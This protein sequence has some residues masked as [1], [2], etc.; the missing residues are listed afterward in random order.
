V[1]ALPIV[2]ITQGATATVCN[3]GSIILDGTGAS[4]YSWSGVDASGNTI[5]DGTSFIPPGSTT[6]TYTVTGTDGNGCTNTALIQVTATTGPTITMS[7]SPSTICAGETVTLTANGLD[8]VLPG[9]NYAWSAGLGLGQTI[10]VTPTTTTT[11]SVTGTDANGCIGTDQQTVMVNP[12]PAAPTINPSSVTEYC[13]GDLNPSAITVTANAGH[14]VNWYNSSMQFLYSGANGPVPNTSNPGTLTYYATQSNQ[15]TG[16][17]SLSLMVEVDIFDLPVIVSNDRTICLG[18]TIILSASGA[19]SGGTYSWSTVG[20]SLSSVNITPTTSGVYTVTGTD[21]NGCAGTKTINVTVNQTPTSP[22]VISPVEYCKDETAVALTASATGGSTL[23]W[24]ELDGVTKRANPSVAPFPQTTSIGSTYYHVSQSN[25]TGCEGPQDSIEVIVHPLPITPTVTTTAYSYCINEPATALAATAKDANHTL[26]WY[27]INGLPTNSSTPPTPSTT[28]QGTVTYS[29]S[30]IN[31][32]TGCESPRVDITVT[33]VNGPGLPTIISPVEYCKDESAIAL[34][35]TTTDAS[36]TLKWYDM[37]GDPI[38][39]PPTPL[40]NFAGTQTY[41]V[42]QVTSSGCEGSLASLSVNVHNNPV[43]E[44]GPNR[45]V[46]EGDQIILAGSGVSNPPTSPAQTYTWSGGV[47]DNIPFAITTT[48]MYTVTGTDI[49]GCFASDDITVTVSSTPPAPT[50]TNTVVE[51]CEGEVSGPLDLEVGLTAPVSGYDFKWYDTDGILLPNAPTHPTGTPGTLTYAVSLVSNDSLGCEGP[52]TLITVIVNELPDAPVTVDI[53]NCFGGTSTA[54]TA[55]AD[56]GN[57]LQWYSTDG[58]TPI[59]TPG[60]PTL[61]VGSVTY[62]VSQIDPTGC[63]SPKASL[64]ITTH[65]VPNIS[66]GSDVTVC[67]GDQVILEGSGG[68]VG[69]SYTWSGGIS[70]GVAF[71]PTN[72]LGET[73]YVTGTDGFGCQ[74]TDTVLVT[75][76]PLPAAPTLIDAS[77]FEY[78]LGDAASPLNTA[79]QVA[80]SGGQRKWYLPGPGGSVSLSGPPTPSTSVVGTFV[81]EVSFVSTNLGCESPKTQITI[82][83][84]DVPSA[85]LTTT[86]EYCLGEPNPLPLTATELAGYTLKWYD[87]DGQ[88]HLN[89]GAPTP[90]T[91]TV[92]TVT[93]YVSQVSPY[94]TI[95]NAQML[96][97]EGVKGTLDVVTHDL[98]TITAVAITPSNTTTICEGDEI[99]LSGQGAGFS[100]TYNWTNGVNDGTAFIPTSTTTY[101]V[102]GVD[103]NTC[104]NIASVTITVNPEPLPFEVTPDVYDTKSGVNY[105]SSICDLDS[106]QLSTNISS[107]TGTVTWYKINTAVTPNDT[108]FFTTGFNVPKTNQAGK[109]FAVY[110][111][112]L[113]CSKISDNYIQL[114]VE[115]LIQPSFFQ[116]PTFYNSSNNTYTNCA[117]SAEIVMNAPFVANASYTILRYNSIASQ[118]DSVASVTS[119]DPSYSPTQSGRYRI[120]AE[121]NGCSHKFSQEIVVVLTDLPKP[122]LSQVFGSGALCNINDLNINIDNEQAYTAFPGAVFTV[123]S[124][125]PDS[126][127]IGNVNQFTKLANGNYAPWS[128][129]VINGHYEDSTHT[130]RFIEYYVQASAGGCVSPIDTLLVEQYYSP[131]ER[132]IILA[133]GVTSTTYNVCSS[134][135]VVDLQPDELTPFVRYEWYDADLYDSNY[136][137]ISPLAQ[138]FD[139]TIYNLNLLNIGSKRLYLVGYTISG[140]MSSNFGEIFVSKSVPTPPTIRYSHTADDTEYICSSIPGIVS[141]DI[142]IETPINGNR[143]ELYRVNNT[144]PG[145]AVSTIEY[146]QEG[147]TFDAMNQIGTYRAFSIDTN[148]CESDFGNSLFMEAV[149]VIKPQIAYPS[150]TNLPL[151]VC[152]NDDVNLQLNNWIAYSNLSTVTD[153]VFSWYRVESAGDVF[154]G[155]SNSSVKQV[156]VGENTTGILSFDAKF[157]V[158]A[159]HVLMGACAMTSDT[160]NIDVRNTPSAPVVSAYP[161]DT[162]CLGEDIDLV[163]LSSDALIPNPNYKWYYVNPDGTLNSQVGIGDT[164]TR[165]PSVGGTYTFAAVAENSGCPGPATTIDFFVRDLTP[166]ILEPV[167]AW[168][169]GVFNVCKDST[170]DLRVSTPMLDGATYELYRKDLISGNFNPYPTQSNVLQ[171]IYDSS[172]PNSNVFPDVEEGEYRVKVIQGN[173]EEFGTVSMSIDEILLNKP[174]I[175]YAPSEPSSLCT[176]STTIL[177]MDGGE[178]VGA[179]YLWNAIDITSGGTSLVTNGSDHS[180]NVPNTNDLSVTPGFSGLGTKLTDYYLTSAMSAS[181]GKVCRT[182]SDTLRITAYDRPAGPEYAGTA[183]IPPI[184]EVCIGSNDIL[185]ADAPTSAVYDWSWYKTN[186]SLAPSQTDVING[187]NSDSLTVSSGG[188]YYASVT[189]A[190]GCMSNR[191]FI[192]EYDFVAPVQAQFEAVA[193]PDNGI[194]QICADSVGTLEVSNPVIGAEYTLYQEDANGAFVRLPATSFTHSLGATPRFTGLGEGIYKVEVDEDL[195]NPI[196]SDAS[197][198]IERITIQDYDIQLVQGYNQEVCQDELT[199]LKLTR[200]LQKI[201][202]GGNFNEIV[203][204]YDENGNFIDDTEILIVPTSS[205]TPS[206]GL[207]YTAEVYGKVNGDYKCPKSP[208]NDF[209]IIV[210]PN[211]P[212]PVL[213][214]QY[215]FCEGESMVLRTMDNTADSNFLSGS[216]GFR[217]YYQQTPL[218]VVDTLISHTSAVLT[219]ND[220][221][222]TASGY[223]STDYISTKGCESETSYYSKVD[224]DSVQTPGFRPLIAPQIWP[225]PLPPNW[226]VGR[227][228]EWLICPNDTSFFVVTNLDP[229]DVG[230]RYHLQMQASNGQWQDIPSR[231]FDYPSATGSTV[232]Q[233]YGF[234][235]SLTG[236]YRVRA[237]KYSGVHAGSCKNKFSAPVYVR[238]DEEPDPIITA[239]NLSLCTSPPSGTPVTSSTT[240]YVTNLPNPTVRPGASY[241]WYRRDVTGLYATDPLVAITTGTLTVSQGG[242]YYA[243]LKYGADS[244]SLNPRTCQV[245]SND[246][247]IVENISP[248]NPNT[249]GAPPYYICEST[250]NGLST[251]QVRIDTVTLRSY[252]NYYWYD[253]NN[254]GVVKSQGSM[255][256][257][258]QGEYQIVAENNGCFSDTFD[259]DI[260][261][262]DID[263]PI[264]TPQDGTIC[265]QDSLLLQIVNPE[266]GIKYKWYRDGT[267]NVLDSGWNY[268]APSIAGAYYTIGY[269]EGSTDATGNTALTCQSQAS[270]FVPI[271]VHLMPSTPVHVDLYMCSDDYITPLSDFLNVPFGLTPYWYISG[272]TEIPL[273]FGDN[274][275]LDQVSFTG[276]DT[277]SLWV[278]YKDD[279]TGCFSARTEMDLYTIQ[280]PTESPIVEDTVVCSGAAFNLG[281]MVKNWTGSN[282]ALRIYDVDGN[283]VSEWNNEIIT[284]DHDSTYIYTFNFGSNLTMN[285]LRCYSGNTQA[286][287]T[288]KAT[289]PTPSVDPIAFSYCEGEDA[290]D[291]LYRLSPYI[292][293]SIT[294][295]LNWYTNPNIN[296][297]SALISAPAI[298]TVLPGAGPV[299]YE[300]WLTRRNWVCE[301]QP[302]QLQIGVN[303][304]PSSSV[305]KD[306]S[307]VLCNQP[308]YQLATNQ[309]YSPLVLSWYSNQP[310]GPGD[311]TGGFV[312]NGLA[313]TE[314]W[315]YA[316]K[317]DAISGCESDFDSVKVRISINQETPRALFGGIDTVICSSQTPFGLN[318]LFD[319]DSLNY[320]LVWYTD[321]SGSN[322]TLIAPYYIP[323]LS[324]DSVAV[325]VGL[326]D[327]EN[328]AGPIT[329]YLIRKSITPSAPITRDTAY[330]LGGDVAPVEDLVNRLPSL[331]YTY[332]DDPFFGQGT[333]AYSLGQPEEDVYVYVSATN[334]Y[335][336]ESDRSIIG[337]DIFKDTG[338][339]ITA[340]P[341]VIPDGGLTTL[342]ATGANTYVF[343]G[344]GSWDDGAIGSDSTSPAQLTLQPDSVGTKWYKVRGTRDS[345]GCIGVDSVQVHVNAFDP[346]TIGFDVEFCAGQR[347]TEVRNVTYP[348]GGSGNYMFEW[349]IGSPVGD[350]ILQVNTPTLTFPLGLL[351][352]SYYQDTLRIMRRAIDSEALAI[353]DTVTISIVNVPPINIVEIDDDYEIPTGHLTNYTAF[354]NHQVDFNVAYKWLIDSVDA[355]VYDDTLTNVYLDSG[356]HV[357]EGRIYYVD[358]LGRMRCHRSSMVTVDVSDLIPGVLNPEQTVCY[359]EKPQDLYVIDSASGGSG[360]Y[361]YSWEFYD[362]IDSVWEPYLDTAG[363]I[364]TDPIL[365]FDPTVGF[366]ESQKFRRVVTDHSVTKFTVATHIT[367]LPKPEPPIVDT[368]IVCFGNWVGALGATPTA[369]YEVEWYNYN[370][371]TSLRSDA[372]VMDSLYAGDQIYYVAQRDTIFG[373]LSDL[374]KVV[375]RMQGLPLPPT[376]IP[377]VVCE[378]DTVQIELSADSTIANYELLWFEKDT[379]T[380]IAGTP[381]ISGA[382]LDSNDRFF[383]AQMDTITGCVSEKVE[384]PI[385]LKYLPEGEIV[386]GVDNFTV[387]LGEYITLSLQPYQGYNQVIWY[388]VTPFDTLI[389]DTAASISVNPTKSTLYLARAITDLNCYVEYYQNVTVQELP[390]SPYLRSYEY[391]QNEDATTIIADSLYAGNAL[392]FYNTLTQIDTVTF[393]P[394]PPT[395]SVGIFKYYA[396]QYDSI[397]G[398]I[399]EIDTSI[400]RVLGRPR[401]PLQRSQYFCLGTPDTLAVDKGYGTDN[402]L[403]KLE[404]FDMDNNGL[405]STPVISTSDT[406][407]FYF[408][409]RNEDLNTGCFSELT[410]IEA[411]VYEHYI[412]SVLYDDSTT[413]FND[414]DAVVTV[415]VEGPFIT[416]WFYVNQNGWESATFADSTSATVPAGQ[417]FV[418]TRDTAGCEVHRDTSIDYFI[419]QEPDM[420]TLDSVHVVTQIQCYDSTDAIIQ[421]WASGGNIIE[422]S[423]DSLNFQSSALFTGLGP[424]EYWPTI[425]DNKGCDWM[426]SSRYDSLELIEPDPIYVNFITEDLLCASDFTGKVTATLQGGNWDS[427]EINYGWNY[428]WVYDST[429]AEY[430]QKGYHLNL[431]NPIMDSLWAGDYFLTAT[432]YKGC[433]LTDTVTLNQPDSVIVDSIYSRNVT[434]FDSSNAIIEIFAN[435]GTSLTYSLD[436]IAT[437]FGTQT[438]WDNLSQ[439]DTLY[440]SVADTNSCFVSYKDNRRVIFDSLELFEATDVIIT[441]PLCFN[442]STGRIEVITKGGSYPL[443]NIDSTSFIYADSLAFNRLPSDTVYITVTDTNSCTPVYAFNRKIFIDQPDKLNVNAITDSNV[444]CFEDTTGIISGTIS[445]GTLPYD[446]LWSNGTIALWDSAVAGGLYYLE[447]IDGNDCYA[448]DSTVV[449]SFDR[450]C[451]GIPDSVETFSDCDWDG[452][453]N[454]YDLDSDNDGIPDALEYDYD[455]NGIVGDDCDGDGIPNYCDP[456]LCEFFIPSVITPNFDGKNDALEIPGLQYFDNYKFTVYNIYGN[457]VF[458][459]VNQGSG[460]GGTTQ[461]RVVWFNNDGELP[462]G[463]YFYVLEIR[464][465]K[466]RQS[467]YIYIAR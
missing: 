63:E 82:I 185:G 397:T 420:L 288:V 350:T 2:G 431:H 461:N 446:V 172:V 440:V 79:L 203:R 102:T 109:Y 412:E 12:V 200:P 293:D 423:V 443:L 62:Y 183:L 370:N 228:P 302:T 273:G 186:N 110:E 304:K 411:I 312:L 409:V 81:Y 450:D 86:V 407:H 65:S 227:G 393:L 396:S 381:I 363:V 69:A 364:V 64:T 338:V 125:A 345:T 320:D 277:T 56:Q 161:T 276:T 77:T 189:D 404:W 105:I 366:T 466:W 463:T 45:W 211:P 94:V 229:Y 373:C 14:I 327:K 349:W 220:V 455:R 255:A 441:E 180:I 235:I 197:I 385:T 439:G 286:M 372:P 335:G 267:S 289:P 275:F 356:R 421:L 346:G 219:I 95:N 419:V 426:N 336:C 389:V 136:P 464:P 322:P 433:F 128:P 210:N 206:S 34:T 384:S 250:T 224:I 448:F 151:T 223:Y 334:I 251:K 307:I 192:M 135:P 89:A 57:T 268:Y 168:S 262:L 355:G 254:P 99:T 100:G 296:P 27:G 218:G 371:S 9:S 59:P 357:I 143:Y 204:W 127:T 405:V 427:T 116:S 402:S 401:P 329:P 181:N 379:V 383:V 148:G 285:G 42:S 342:T 74:N 138:V 382:T 247:L 78:C 258:P 369:G 459:S 170:I 248:I 177:E 153:Y 47:T 164:L 451:D 269:R 131:T 103:G 141:Y 72:A 274:V 294:A 58:I 126:S 175:T 360:E 271:S 437:N 232:P 115:D 123:T 462:S 169:G 201:A 306:D 299:V 395:D 122:Q 67:F 195:C 326:V 129:S 162:I 73:Y 362:P 260:L 290:G 155:T 418:Y 16:C 263:R 331:I 457:R 117:I 68:G 245:V 124:S 453:P 11:Y 425:R 305:F 55:V 26:K 365:A 378:N 408:K 98:P 13:K 265:P 429:T 44:A 280:T 199:K 97:C 376:V 241:W 40:T 359:N 310:F 264:V 111:N 66:G 25:G 52:T 137:N 388:E 392:L 145:P 108:V 416:E 176:D 85:P 75:A 239:T 158:V 178:T 428:L 449:G 422:Y 256:Q 4:T 266:T 194:Y 323:F 193:D 216:V 70:N 244:T 171:F 19:G 432:D 150:G 430:G 403:Y 157:Y 292:N 43:V 368:P 32:T 298:S 84:N 324:T 390:I 173:C 242:T 400:V 438:Y 243:I 442:D 18:D 35:A 8:P 344:P 343:Y 319:Y 113:G 284:L 447:V 272:D 46:C 315:Y 37:A 252:Y 149:Q 311:T 237:Q 454:A 163:A 6:T 91:S 184:I 28:T 49:N 467:G 399:S 48:Q 17:E 215:S 445:G 297:D 387:C 54:L 50:T 167:T 374:E 30:Q 214:D 133:D 202:T 22:T 354:L 107:T 41:F 146:P 415:D 330:C 120:R 348:S 391:C 309:I 182:Y 33:T 316:T 303:P 226:P 321:T 217:W 230:N 328:C 308:N 424:D 377:I 88:T 152:E 456:D 257:F 140:C 160:F 165:A 213:H 60:A 1:N 351:P 278:A 24:F 325:Y 270:A 39:A 132:P 20:T 452:I 198:E 38:P 188:Y 154:L 29:V 236:N 209:K 333:G 187:A 339:Y 380:G 347:P 23:Q 61:N 76:N 261:Q 222:T 205:A 80:V 314:Q 221:P 36:Y 144:T 353:S 398:C 93:Y 231:Y 259:F 118:W 444:T 112:A 358:T 96:G 434:C 83:V 233:N 71:N 238:V 413:C 92:G 249:E 394:V 147:D 410:V 240:L 7:A 166:P 159:E 191:T 318:E 130:N 313:P 51:Y 375:F 282:Y 361:F 87:T 281:N 337:I 134:D 225:A 3:N 5:V 53:D 435:G 341:V 114:D 207:Y 295:N 208:D 279:Q 104:E 212:A 414:S 253:K 31:N 283:A 417:Y 139:S 179:Y 101:T 352:Q 234:D 15:S 106:I 340:A 90:S 246:I 10:T 21:A 142:E 458:E 190:N 196:L 291:M 317:V 436:T 300:Y 332:Y 386:G 119:T 121:L 460:F 465:D 367:V 301:S 406:G 287:L 156:N 174:D